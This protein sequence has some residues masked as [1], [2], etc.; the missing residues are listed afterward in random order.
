MIYLTPHSGLANRIRAIVSGISLA[1]HLGMPITIIWEK[2]EGCNIN[3]SDLFKPI[4]GITVVNRH[5]KASVE[6]IIR[7]KKYFK[8]VHSLVGIDFYMFDENFKDLVWC[9]EDHVFKPEIIKKNVRDIYINTC[10]DFYYKKEFVNLFKPINDIEI[11]IE[12]QI[13]KFSSKTIGIHIRRSDNV[14]SIQFS[15]LELYIHQMETD[16]SLDN[17]ID[18]FLATDDIETERTLKGIFP[19]KILTIEKELAR[20]SKTGM[21]GAIVDLFCL[22]KCSK[23]YGSY[24]SS[25]SDVAARIGDIPNIVMKKA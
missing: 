11:L 3:F 8:W 10:F 17:Q 19:G 20:N 12:K 23:I 1:E 24:W 13:E 25:F 14:K 6:K 15:S 9:N 5:W 18:F 21:L 22:A 4:H 16:L 7:G 2:D